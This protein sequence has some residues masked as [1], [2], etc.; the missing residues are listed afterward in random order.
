[1]DWL[2]E[3]WMVVTAFAVGIGAILSAMSAYSG[4][5]GPMIATESYV[6]E[7][8]EIAV[9]RARSESNRRD[10]EAGERLELAMNY[11]RGTH[12]MVLLSEWDRTYNELEIVKRQIA[13]DANRGNPDKIELLI[14]RSGILQMK[15]RQVESEL[16]KFDDDRD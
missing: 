11:S 12:H 7:Q 13:S 3:K 2:K 14:K 4:M 15:M 8:I 6:E 10:D 5:G 9:E 1:L 16:D